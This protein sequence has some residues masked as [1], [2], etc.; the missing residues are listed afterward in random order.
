[1]ASKQDGGEVRRGPAGQ[2]AFATLQRSRLQPV[3]AVGR[4]GWGLGPLTPGPHQ[5][6][7]APPSA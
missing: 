3:P 5:D 6:R 7:L 1:M 4:C 2:C